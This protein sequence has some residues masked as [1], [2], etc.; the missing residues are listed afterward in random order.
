MDPAGKRVII[1]GGGDTA[2]D[3]MGTALRLNVKTVNAFE[4]L[5]TP[6]EMRKPEVSTI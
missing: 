6:P 5:P 2:T 3:C 1:L 4:I